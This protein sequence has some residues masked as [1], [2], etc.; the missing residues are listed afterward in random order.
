MIPALERETVSRGL[1]V[2][3]SVRVEVQL[4]GWR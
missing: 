2:R 4:G 1:R 3:L